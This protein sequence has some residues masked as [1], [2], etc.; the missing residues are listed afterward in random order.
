MRERLNWIDWLKVIVVV[1]AFV[2]HAAQPFVLTTWLI[3]DE[4]KSLLLS[5][6][7]GF[8]YMVGMPLMFFL[9]GAAT[10]L[11]VERR[12]IGGHT[13]LRL[14]RLLVPLVLGMVILGPPQAWVA[15]LAAGGQA[16]PVEF[17]GMYLG[18]IRLS[19]N[20]GWFGEY[21]HHLW[22][23]A[24]LF[25]Y[26]LLTLPLLSWLRARRAAGSDLRIGGIANGPGGL[27]WLLL[28]IV[29]AQ[30]ILRPLFPDYRDWADFALWLSYF[31][32]GIGA[33]ADPRLMDAIRR[34]RRVT[35]WLAPLVAIGYLPIVLF[36]SPLDIEH[37]PGFTVAG[38]V[39]VAWRTALGW[40][41][42]LILVGVAATYF[43]SR[44]RFLGWASDMV[45]PFYV[46][47]HPVTVLVAAMVVGLSVGLW[48]KFGLILLVAGVTTVA[49]CVAFDIATAAANGRFR[50]GEP[51]PVQPAEA[52]P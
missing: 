2:F 11:A 20:P 30:L 48:V 10:W 35:L 36:G 37:A 47:H 18:D 50:R 4:D 39:Y 16:G 13:G 29:A 41:M 19:L 49:L 38:L 45:L 7:S 15:Y 24:F 52:P 32:I 34:R 51:A 28:P 5:F 12:G 26:V 17:L 44:P 3:N 40:V 25:L 46:L 6:L 23:L 31:V 22:F 42:T 8:G 1:G 33:M 21:G 9:A 43:T 27:V 14:R